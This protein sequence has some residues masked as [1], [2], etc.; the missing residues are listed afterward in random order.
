MLYHC[1]SL[2]MDLNW[3]YSTKQIKQLLSTITLCQKLHKNVKKYFVTYKR[4]K[5]LINWWHESLSQDPLLWK[6]WTHLFNFDPDWHKSGCKVLNPRILFFQFF[7][8]SFQWLSCIFIILSSC[9]KRE[10]DRKNTS[11]TFEKST[12]G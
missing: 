9:T 3:I 12:K 10:L 6:K 2:L 8:R 5:K 7:F 1:L 11:S 4:T